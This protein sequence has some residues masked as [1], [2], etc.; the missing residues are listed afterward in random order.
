M[1]VIALCTA[2]F[3]RAKNFAFPPPYTLRF[4]LPTSNALVPALYCLLLLLFY[5]INRIHQSLETV[6][7]KAISVGWNNNTGV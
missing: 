1:L 2:C 5:K 4:G 7:D 3:F 6:I